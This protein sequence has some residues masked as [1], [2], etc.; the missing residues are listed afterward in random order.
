MRT[1]KVNRK[2]G[3]NLHGGE[4]IK[5]KLVTQKEKNSRRLF[6]DEIEEE[7]ETGYLNLKSSGETVFDYYDDEYD[8]EDDFGEDDLDVDF[9]EDDEDDYNDDLDDYDDEDDDLDDED[10][11]DDDLDDEDDSDDDE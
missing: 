2:A 10:D 9:E 4:Q 6:F 5:N 8:D 11:Y 7:E 1:D 3:N